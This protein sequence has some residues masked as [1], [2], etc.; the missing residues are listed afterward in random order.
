MKSAPR[1]P[2]RSKVAARRPAEP[3]AVRFGPVPSDQAL[4]LV[5]GHN[6]FRP[7]GSRLLRKG[8]ALTEADVRSL[9]EFGIPQ[10]WVARLDPDDVD[11]DRCAQRV[12]T[13]LLADRSPADLGL[14]ASGPST[15]RV[16]LRA[17]R[18]GLAHVVP[19]P[20]HR[21]NGID[22]VTVATVAP[23]SVVRPGRVLATVKILPYA[24]PRESLE[25]ACNALVD[26]SGP[27]IAL[28]P[29]ERR[30]VALLVTGHPGGRERTLLGF[31]TA[32]GDRLRALGSD[33]DR[34]EFVDDGPERDAI[35]ALVTAIVGLRGDYDL[36]LIAG[37]TAIQDRHDAAPTAIEAA[38]GRIRSYGAPVDPG[39]L[40][41][42]AEL[43]GKP[44]MGVPGCAR[45][46]KRNIVDLVLPRLLAG[47]AVDGA[48]IDALGVGG[49][50]DD[51]PDRPLPREQI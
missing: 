48:D 41:L 23:H 7:D 12:A 2:K 13:A 19:S 37:E 43:D 10:V 24:L 11:E 49:L 34:T 4:G 25:R 3:F 28:E 14:A 36:L 27:V 46:P 44:V 1:S 45:S 17:A 50:L 16:N 18:L 31:E 38:G 15:G 5:L 22:G 6:V 33:L 47:H 30:R 9:E 20:I 51:V 40:L 26:P 8:L 42:L 35:A 32:L 21:V 29:L 39:N